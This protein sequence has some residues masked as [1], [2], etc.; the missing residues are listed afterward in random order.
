MQKKK[1]LALA[2]TLLVV[3]GAVV[4]HYTGQRDE[5]LKPQEQVIGEINSELQAL[6]AKGFA[7]T[8]L[9]AQDRKV[10]LHRGFGIAERSTGRAVTTET[11]FDIGSLVKPFTA[12]AILKLEGQGKLR[13][14]DP[15]TNFFS[16]VPLDK[17]QITVQELLTHTSGLPD[18]VDAESKEIEYT[19]NF[20]Y[21]PVARDEIVRRA[22]HT[23]LVNTP[24]TK[25]EYSNLGYS[26]LGVII[27]LAS[28]APY[29]QF[30]REAI[31]QPAGMT[32]TGYRDPDWKTSELAV[33]Y[34]KGQAWGT[35]LDHPWRADGPSWNLR[36][37]GG[38]LST[39]ED[40]YKWIEALDE[41]KVLSPTEK[42]A[43][44]ALNVHANQR[45]T[46]TM[47]VAGSNEIFDA[48]YLWYVDEHR[49]LVMLTNSDKYRAEKMIP[50]LA[51][52]MRSIRMVATSDHNH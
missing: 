51:K 32:R 43:F 25:S 2:A 20:D 44:F 36:G 16:N 1:V 27:E 40:L 35:P 48:C 7:G 3:A 15:I 45:G 23:K 41:D 33:G 12:A 34:S 37:N 5:P 39:A 14:S 38:M 26:L 11:G 22:L 47:G 4:W 6:T 21:E 10:L 24:G 17:A 30:V 50:D 42:E 13:R 9:L 46:R 52:K 18:I 8:V 49:V 29:E 28:G 31:F 19:P